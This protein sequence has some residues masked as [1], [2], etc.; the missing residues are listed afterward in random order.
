M[1]TKNF[2]TLTELWHKSAQ[3]QLFAKADQLDFI[4]S[5]DTVR[6]DNVL[7]CDSMEFDFDMGRDLWLTRGRFTILQRDYLDIRQLDQFLDGCEAIGLGEAKRGVITEMA[8]R[9]HKRADKKYRW[10]NCM[11]GYTF[12]GGN[13]HDLRILRSDGTWIL[14]SS[15]GSSLSRTSSGLGST[16]CCV[17]KPN[18]SLMRI[19]PRSS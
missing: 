18:G 2:P 16:M 6:Y 13:K 1:R 12:R 14:F 17:G 7:R 10:G 19:T 9:Q 3:S 8:C 15:T 4:A 11:M 5:I